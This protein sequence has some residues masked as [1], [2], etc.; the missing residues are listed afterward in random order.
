MK[1]LLPV[2]ALIL[3]TGGCSGDQRGRDAV[4]ATGE[5]P[6]QVGRPRADGMTVFDYGTVAELAE[7]VEAVAVVRVTAQRETAIDRTGF[8]VST[9]EVV[10]PIKGALHSGQSIDVRQEG[11][12]DTGARWEFPI[13]DVGTTYVTFVDEAGIP[14]DGPLPFFHL[15][16]LYGADGN[17]WV[18]LTAEPRVA[19]DEKRLTLDE[20]RGRVAG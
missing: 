2:L 13:L 3:A 10:D 14:N 19:D 18:E 20:L 4:A 11:H 5:S 15:F 8:T 6:T 7:I 12:R 17:E 9:V 16:G 1:K